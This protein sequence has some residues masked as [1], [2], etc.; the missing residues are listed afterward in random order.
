MNNDVKNKLVND[1]RNKTFKTV[2]LRE[3]YNMDVV[4]AFLDRIVNLINADDN[5]SMIVNMIH[6]S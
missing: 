5:V 4:D 3:G 1:I 6:D 2:S